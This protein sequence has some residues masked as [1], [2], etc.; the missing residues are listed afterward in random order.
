MSSSG[1]GQITCRVPQCPG[2]P[3]LHI[4]HFHEGAFAGIEHLCPDHGQRYLT[5]AK[6]TWHPP[7]GRKGT[8]DKPVPM[9]LDCIAFHDGYPT[10]G[11]ILREKAGQRVFVLPGDYYTSAAIS[12]SFQDSPR[13]GSARAMAM[14][15]EAC[16]A[17]LQQVVVE[18]C[19]NAGHYHTAVTINTD[20]GTR[21]LDLRPS[22]ALAL[23]NV[24][25]VPFLVS[26]SLLCEDHQLADTHG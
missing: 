1:E 26:L 8:R 3:V 19:D 10:T 7:S 2:A 9:V 15:L 12:Q 5:L 17:S 13:P 18:E 21:T 11:I 14:L 4:T 24:C 16:G 23:S 22:D 6:L 20:R 25:E